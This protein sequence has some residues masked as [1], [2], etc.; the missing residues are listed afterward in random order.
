MHDFSSHILSAETDVIHPHIIVH[1]LQSCCV[2]GTA[3]KVAPVSQ[4]A[5]LDP[6]FCQQQKWTD[7]GY[8]YAVGGALPHSPSQ[9]SLRAGADAQA[10]EGDHSRKSAVQQHSGQPGGES[11][12]VAAYR[13][14]LRQA[15]RSGRSDTGAIDSHVANSNE[16]ATNCCKNKVS[17]EAAMD[18]WAV[19]ERGA[20]EWHVHA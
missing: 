11:G 10:Y 20:S 8:G 19:G 1:V 3:R 5:R 2:G 12:R 6:V 4:D 13:P 18:G 9:Q 16:T 15:D 14:D 17:A 7:A